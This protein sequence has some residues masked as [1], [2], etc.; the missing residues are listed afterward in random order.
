MTARFRLFCD[1]CQT[2]TEF[3]PT[4]Q[5]RLSICSRCGHG[6]VSPARTPRAPRSS[7]LEM[8]QPPGDR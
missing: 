6:R 2:V 7:W 3:E 8:S 5:P 4:D 1:Q